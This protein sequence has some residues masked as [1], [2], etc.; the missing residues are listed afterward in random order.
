MPESL[1]LRIEC[2]SEAPRRVEVRFDADRAS[3][4]IGSSAEA[5]VRI[6]HPTVGGRQCRLTRGADGYRLE[7]LDE[8]WGTV[9][10]GT[11][12]TDSVQIGDGDEI[13]A[14]S[15]VMILEVSQETA[16]GPQESL[17]AS[18]AADGGTVPEGG[19]GAGDDAP[20]EPALTDPP[21]DDPSESAVASA[22]HDPE[23][24]NQPDPEVGKPLEASRAGGSIDSEGA[25]GETS[26]GDDRSGA[27][28]CE[29]RAEAGIERRSEPH[30]DPGTE[31]AVESKA[32]PRTDP[33]TDPGAQAHAE[34][35]TEPQA[36]QRKS[37]GSWP[38]TPAGV[39][40]RR[41]ED[42]SPDLVGDWDRGA[43][44]DLVASAIE[45]ASVFGF[46]DE[47][48]VQDYL[49][50]VL[51]LGGPIVDRGCAVPEVY[52]ALAHPRKSVRERLDRALRL[53]RQRGGGEEP[54]SPGSARGDATRID[55]PPTREQAT[56]AGAVPASGPDLA[57]PSEASGDDNGSH[58]TRTTPPPETLIDEPGEGVPEMAGYEVIERIGSGGMG[59]VYR[60]HDQKL[61][62]DVAI[63]VIRS[64]HPEAQRQL[65]EEARSAAKLRHPNIV[66]VS[67]YEQHGRGGYYVMQ[68]VEGLDASELL[69]RFT[70]HAAYDERI[71]RVLD[72][73]DLRQSE[74]CPELRA[75][76]GGKQA[77][78]RLI[79]WWMAG[80]GDGLEV[81]HHRRLIHRDIK[82]SNLLL[83][84]EGRLMIA[85][86]GLAAR[87]GGSTGEGGSRVGTPR[88]L[89][90]ERV[91]EWADPSGRL[92][93]DPRGDVW[94]LGV[95]F[96]EFLALKAPF[97]GTTDEV[98]RQIVSID[99][100]PPS[101]L[102]WSVP[103]ELEQICM[104]ALRR[105]AEDRY[106]RAGDLAD[107]LRT[108]LAGN[109]LPV[110]HGSPSGVW[111]W[112]G[113]RTGGG[114]RS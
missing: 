58:G 90:P 46:K 43:L 63:K 84:P 96:Y 18:E 34:S 114:G 93:G 32:E 100:C 13:E 82:P 44:L 65:L 102:C 88:Y 39:A 12:I 92:V 24:G 79:A 106:A 78:Y 37:G 49:R 87:R 76:L 111:S 110:R 19:G 20:A 73:A 64:L 21:I 2:R 7:N 98:L 16:S 62:I 104:R 97:S 69:A 57:T 38:D 61:D 68:L 52:F 26:E 55:S 42:A 103:S 86:F 29:P 33:G 54:D 94:S 15:V 36:E 23:P 51:M 30:V 91:A 50:C 113:S 72:L 17:P 35:G 107:D 41:L 75:V 95:T 74:L 56:P 5:D 80:V 101:D 27:G 109:P 22:P 8:E 9:V 40:C 99:P 66:Q 89:A 48:D 3:V 71:D 67:R 28:P 45:Q 83:S 77:Y 85:D 10:N 81:A 70:D 59:T 14:G 53:A 112:L 11:E 108:W 1:Q 4:V 31:P 60:A 105:D 6:D 47:A 25:A